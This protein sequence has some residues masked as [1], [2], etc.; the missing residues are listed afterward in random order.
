MPGREKP[1]KPQQNSSSRIATRQSQ[2][3]S[4]SHDNS[5][6]SIQPA[7]CCVY[8]ATFTDIEDKLCEFWDESWKCLDGAGLTEDTYNTLQ[9]KQT[10][11]CGSA[12]HAR[13]SKTCAKCKYRNK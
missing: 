1:S 9:E 10:T 5:L 11:L 4:I 8:K 2:S 7:E 6:S 3:Q 12:Q 13:R